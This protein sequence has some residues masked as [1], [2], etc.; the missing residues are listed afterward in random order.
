MRDN[1][2][3]SNC[4]KPQNFISLLRIVLKYVEIA[5]YFQAV[6]QTNVNTDTL[7]GIAV[8]TL[9]MAGAMKRSVM[10]PDLIGSRSAE[11]FGKLCTEAIVNEKYEVL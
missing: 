8:A 1:L 7:L 5:P 9:F 11:E 4:G 3:K 6:I 10:S 2:N